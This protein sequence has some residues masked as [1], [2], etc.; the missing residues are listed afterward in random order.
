[1]TRTR[2]PWA[3]FVA[4]LVL[5]LV[6][7]ACAA[8]GPREVPERVLLITVDTLR[9]DHVAGSAGASETPMPFV[10]ALIARGTRFSRAVTPVPR[11][12]QALAS[13]LTG[14]YPHGTGV[15]VL[16][17]RLRDDVVT[18]GELVG[19]Q[20]FRTVAVVSNHILTRDRGLDRGFDVYDTAG[21]VR[22]A[23]ETTD[24]ALAAT[25]NLDPAE[26]LFLWVHYID[27]HVPYHPPPE[28]AERF[29]PDYT[30]PYKYYFGPVPGAVGNR[31]YPRGLGK[32]RAVFSNPFSDRVNEHV[33]RLYAADAR[34][35]DRE[36]ERLVAGLEERFGARWLV[37][38]SSDHGESLGEHGFHYDHGDYVYN[39]SIR[40]PLAFVRP[41]ARASDRRVVDAPVSLV[42]VAP[43]LAELLQ[44][45]PVRPPAEGFE[46]RSLVPYLDGEALPAQPVFAESGKSYFPDMI[47]GRITFDVRGRFRSV[48][49]GD[50]KLIWTPGQTGPREYQLYDI[51]NDPDEIHDLSREFPERVRALAAEITAWMARAPGAQTAGAPAIP[52]SDRDALEALGY[53]EE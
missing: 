33:R 12:T 28:L 48:V 36:I 51:A 45:P 13:L 8:D 11:T 22:G 38:F 20:G 15:R 50:W 3:R 16:T 10:E 53:I 7:L 5:P 1:M 29:D 49:S 39:A 43:T 27:P 18:I 44:L 26:K 17:D 37:I 9:A 21:D 4:S 41:D 31:A 2:R 42:D 35:A 23:K 25:A 6:G 14:R 46:G 24:A 19:K 34:Y 40:V 32:R 52:E 30:G 47:P